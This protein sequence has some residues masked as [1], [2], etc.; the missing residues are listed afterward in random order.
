[1]SR[2]Y[3]PPSA[4]E[5]PDPGQGWVN[6]SSAVK[7]TWFVDEPEDAP[8]YFFNANNGGVWVWESEK[9]RIL[10]FSPEGRC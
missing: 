10:D 6:V 3:V 5:W 9:R 2:F 1:M 7:T 8:L 4:E